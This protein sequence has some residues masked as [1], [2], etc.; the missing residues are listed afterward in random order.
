M[1][2]TLSNAGNTAGD[3][4][5]SPED[6]DRSSLCSAPS[7]RQWTKYRDLVAPHD[8]TT[9]DNLFPSYPQLPPSPYLRRFTMKTANSAA[10]VSRIRFRATDRGCQP[11]NS[12]LTHYSQ[13]TS[14]FFSPFACFATQEISISVIAVRYTGGRCCR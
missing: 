10:L 2:V 3:P 6:T 11:L 5:I 1:R 13:A 7:T 14:W 8:D 12:T 4:T 9:P